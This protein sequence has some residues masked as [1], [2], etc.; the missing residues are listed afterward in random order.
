MDDVVNFE[1]KL[2]ASGYAGKK[3]TVVLHEAGKTDP[4]AEVEVTA[5]SDGQSQQVRLPYR[6]RKVGHFRYVVEVTP[7]DGELQTENNRQIRAVE[8]RKEKI[9]VLLA[10]A[11]PNYE[12]R[13]LRSML[14]RDDTMELHTVLQ[15]ADA[16]YD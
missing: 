9:R 1:M 14:G 15:D 2:T 7:Q 12:F 5:G 10:Q 8:V 6:P 11:Y 13:Y 3:V 4:L 16:G